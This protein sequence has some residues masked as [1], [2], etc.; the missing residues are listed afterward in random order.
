MIPSDVIAENPQEL[1]KPFGM[2]ACNPVMYLVSSGLVAAGVFLIW[3]PLFYY[4]TRDRSDRIWNRETRGPPA[5]ERLQNIAKERRD[6]MD[7]L[8]SLQRAGNGYTD[9]SGNYYTEEDADRI[10]QRYAEID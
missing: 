6:L 3:I 10:A 8:S 4:L 7:L 5:Q 9:P 2:N 1:I